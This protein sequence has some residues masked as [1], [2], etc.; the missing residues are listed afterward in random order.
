MIV[1]TSLGGDKSYKSK[2]VVDCTVSEMVKLDKE[3]EEVEGTVLGVGGDYVSMM[4]VIY[5]RWMI[6]VS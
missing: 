3:E 1:L 5:P 6:S 2:K 4:P